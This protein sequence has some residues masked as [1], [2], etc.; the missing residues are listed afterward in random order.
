M[1][2]S[3]SLKILF[4][5]EYFAPHI[6]GVERVTQEVGKRLARKGHQIYVFTTEEEKHVGLFRTY[7]YH[8]MTI[9]RMRVPNFAGRYIFALIS[10][11][12]LFLKFS[13]TDIIHSAN[14]Y[15]VALP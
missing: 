8:G 6:G 15:T 2:S 7:S 12:I 13:D 4:I 5:I 3:K 14:N 10:F 11:P 9:T 1:A